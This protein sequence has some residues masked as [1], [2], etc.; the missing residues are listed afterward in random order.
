MKNK[1]FKTH[2]PVTL[3]PAA[4]DELCKSLA[5]RNIFI[6]GAGIYG[7]ATKAA[8]EKSGGNVV[9]F[10]DG[11][12]LK[13]TFNYFGT[14][15][16]SPEKL[17]EKFAEY[18]GNAAV[19]LA[20]QPGLCPSAEDTKEKLVLSGVSREQIFVL[21]F[22][23]SE[24]PVPLP[25]DIDSDDISDFDKPLLPPQ[26]YKPCAISEEEKIAVHLQFFREPI[27][28]IIR[29]V[30]CIREQSYKNLGIVIVSNGCDEKRVNLL[31]QFAEID[32][33]IKLIICEKNNLIS[34]TDYYLITDDSERYYGDRICR[35]D[36]DDYYT[37]DFIEKTV[38]AARRDNADI[39]ICGTFFYSES[40][41]YD[42]YSLTPAFSKSTYSDKKEIGRF[43]CDYGIHYTAHWGKLYSPP[44]F[45]RFFN[46]R[47]SL[48]DCE[49]D[50][51]MTNQ[52]FTIADITPTFCAY[53]EC[54]KISVLPG[55]L[56]FYTR[57][58]AAMTG[59]SGNT[60]HLFFRFYDVM[61]KLQPV[62]K[63]GEFDEKYIDEIADFYLWHMAVHRDL[64]HLEEKVHT[65]REDAKAALLNI[66]KYITENYAETDRHR[67]AIKRIDEILEKTENEK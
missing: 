4:A 58:T 5:G 31:R 24:M 57:R 26:L 54:E 18:G 55:V 16:I 6:Y 20:L 1:N 59:I 40:E 11:S 56:H 22:A 14:G 63:S 64:I 67:A 28:Y 65:N 53:S 46:Y 48:R 12:P 29:A 36:G 50:G 17:P 62:L 27:P 30:Q 49:R 8:A 43:L 25:I 23:V 15:V 34:N 9:C 51:L 44:A 33:R 45:W 32:Q 66:K 61:D 52:T 39:V 38:T 21:P 19:I 7:W 41:P 3:N 35:L 42:L 37:P 47:L 60:A 2:Y 10:C 13:Q